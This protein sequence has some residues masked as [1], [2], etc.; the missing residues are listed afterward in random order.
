MC[1]ACSPIVPRGGKLLHEWASL[2]KLAT[3][4]HTTS[5]FLVARARHDMRNV[6]SGLHV[7]ARVRQSDERCGFS[8][9]EHCCCRGRMA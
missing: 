8:L 3:G 1:L 4:S 6:M 9:E 2:V 5:R 7:K